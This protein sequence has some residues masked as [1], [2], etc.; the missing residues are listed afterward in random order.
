M[1]IIE[2]IYDIQTGEETLVE[3]EENAAEKEARLNHAK[4]VA[5]MQAEAELRAA[6]KAPILERLGITDDEAKLLLS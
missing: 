4:E 3:R 2:K 6:Q 1:K 5:A